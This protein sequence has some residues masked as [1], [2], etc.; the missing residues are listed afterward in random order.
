[1]WSNC[2]QYNLEG[3]DICG[4][5]AQAEAAFLDSWAAQGLPLQADGVK[6]RVKL[7]QA[8][9]GHRKKRWYQWEDR[10]LLTAWAG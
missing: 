6:I 7:P 4:L 2:R 9:A 3:S 5:A 1:M 10:E 8:Q